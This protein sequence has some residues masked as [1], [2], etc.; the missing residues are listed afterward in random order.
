[1]TEPKTNYPGEGL[2]PAQSAV[3]AYKEFVRRWDMMDDKRGWYQL[4]AEERIES[5]F[6]SQRHGEDEIEVRSVFAQI[7]DLF[8]QA[9]F[10]LFKLYLDELAIF[11]H[12]LKGQTAN[13]AYQQ[14]VADGTYHN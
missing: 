14:E 13:Y 4:V 12:R 10:E 6:S 5:V 8:L 7:Q 2:N 1:M 3:N 11:T 9:D